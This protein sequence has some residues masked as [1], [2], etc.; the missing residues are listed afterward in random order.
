VKKQTVADQGAALVISVNGEVAEIDLSQ[1]QD[2]LAAMYTQ[3]ECRSVDVVRLTGQIDMWI[4]D[5]GLYTQ[6]INP[7]ATLLAQRYGFV[8]QPYH[9]PVLLCGVDDEGASVNL[10]RDQVLAVLA[11]LMDVASQLDRHS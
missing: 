10:T 5:E 3:L 4:D 7:A 2:T 9:G 6:K 11:A 8:W 1:P